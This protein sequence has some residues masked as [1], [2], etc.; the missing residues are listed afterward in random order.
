MYCLTIRSRTGCGNCARCSGP[1]STSPSR[2][3]RQTSRSRGASTQLSPKSESMQNVM[4][5]VLHA[6]ICFF[7]CYKHIGVTDILVKYHFQALPIALKYTMCNYVVMLSQWRRMCQCTEQ[8]TGGVCCG[9]R[10]HTFLIL[11]AGLRFKIHLGRFNII[12]GN[13]RW[14]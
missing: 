1:G 6:F 2:A 14:F 4:F 11:Y 9:C 3:T 10:I 13:V 7:S 12:V 5:S 8:G